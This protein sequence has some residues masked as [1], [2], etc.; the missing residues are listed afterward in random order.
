MYKFIREYGREYLV[1]EKEIRAIE[2]MLDISFPPILKKFY[3]NYNGAR[4]YLCQFW[5]DGYEYEISE[6]VY[7]KYGKCSLENVIKNDRED[8][9]IPYNMIPI[10]NN[11]GGDY[12]Y[13]DALSEN[14]FLYY[15]DDIEN[16][17]FICDNINTL[18]KIM[19]NNCSN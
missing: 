15:C 4:I 3:I 17:I 9:I 13:W 11:R 12:Y 10:A 8:N 6:L 16:P 1:N 14:V 5:V 18:F 19:D 2:E 7:L